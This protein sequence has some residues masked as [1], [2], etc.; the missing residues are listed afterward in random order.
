MARRGYI[1]ISGSES[2]IKMFKE[3]LNIKKI[4]QKEIGKKYMNAVMMSIDQDLYLELA[5][6]YNCIDTINK[7]V[8]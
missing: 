7:I 5:K 8:R 6:K 3:F 1:Y 2:E 4:S